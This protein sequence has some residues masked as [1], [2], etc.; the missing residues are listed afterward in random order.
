M[1]C[2]VLIIEDEPLIASFIEATLEDAGATSF[3][4]VDTEADALA[5]V[6][7]RRPDMITS[8]VR[9][10]EGSGPLA[11][12][13][14]QSEYGE[15]PVIFLTAT[16]HACPP[17]EHPRMILSKPCT[18]AR[19]SDAFRTILSACRSETPI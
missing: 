1:P 18:S 10:R 11:V 5:A 2:H 6:Q 15:I 3:D 16:P 9:L 14:I 7:R 12:K 17:C 13:A 4:I 19:L 8:D